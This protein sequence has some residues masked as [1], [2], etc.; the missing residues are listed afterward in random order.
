MGSPLVNATI[1]AHNGPATIRFIPLIVRTIRSTKPSIKPNK[2]SD[3]ENSQPPNI[4]IYFDCPLY[5][6]TAYVHLF[7]PLTGKSCIKFILTDLAFL[8]IKDGKFHLLERVPNVTVQEI[9]NLTEGELVVP[10]HV[11]EMQ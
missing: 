11:P 4:F 3:I 7:I 2:L 10:S 5:Y 9:I 8:E 1:S 6:G